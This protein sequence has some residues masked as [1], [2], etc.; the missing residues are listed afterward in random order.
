MQ[1][2]LVGDIA[3]A[4]DREDEVFRRILVPPREG[5]GPLQ[6]IMRAVD[7]DRVDLAAGVGELVGLAQSPRV[8]RAA[9]VAVVPAG[10]AD[11]DPLSTTHRRALWDCGKRRTC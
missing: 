1:L 7:L 4:L 2:L 6:G 3:A 8:E 10:N 11:L 5:I 9:P